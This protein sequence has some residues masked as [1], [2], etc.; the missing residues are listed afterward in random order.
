MSCKLLAFWLEI[1]SIFLSYMHE[2]W[3]VS[4]VPTVDNKRASH[5]TSVGC[6]CTVGR[7]TCHGCDH[8][9]PSLFFCHVCWRPHIILLANIS[10]LW[11]VVFLGHGILSASLWCCHHHG[12]LIL[13]TALSIVWINPL[14]SLSWILG[15]KLS[16]L[17]LSDIQPENWELW[18]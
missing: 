15:G 3:N 16:I 6:P 4:F 1:A 13:Y 18:C 2:T 12:D 8:N 7:K 5:S 9:I 14:P 11:E 17:S 10:F